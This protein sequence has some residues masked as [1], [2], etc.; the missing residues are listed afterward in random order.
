MESRC[1]LQKLQSGATLLVG[2]IMVLLISI[3]GLSAIRGSGLQEQMAGNMRDKQLAFQSSEAAL[4]QAEAAATPSVIG[5]QV[6][7]TDSL[8]ESGLA[9]WQDLTNW[10]SFTTQYTGTIDHVSEQPH[11]LVEEVTFFSSG[12]EGSAVDLASLLAKD[13]E[14]RYRVTS[15]AAGGSTDARVIVQSG[16]RN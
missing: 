15:H 3:I 13:I 12:L 10:N 6:G 16:F 5:A 8:G 9:F 2:L 4:R 7:F 11:Y 14:R 1:K